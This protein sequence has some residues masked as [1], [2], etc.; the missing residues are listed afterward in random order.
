MSLSDQVALYAIRTT[1]PTHLQTAWEEYGETGSLKR[2]DA[3]RFGLFMDWLITGRR[4]NGQ[5]ILQKFEAEHGANLDPEERAELEKHKATHNGIY[6]VI[7]LRP[8]T[9]V[10]VKDIFTDEETEVADVSASRSAAIWD[11]LLMR[12]RRLGG[13]AQA[14]GEAIVFSPLNRDELKFELE[15]AYRTRKVYDSK[16]DWVSFLDSAT[17]LLRVLEA[18]FRTRRKTIVDS[19]H[20][21]E[22]S[23]DQELAAV[24]AQSG[25]RWLDERI[26]ALGG[27]TPR[28]AAADPEARG[29][30]MDLLKEYERNQACIPDGDDFAGY[31]NVAPIVWMRQTLGLPIPKALAARDKK[32][33]AAGRR[34]KRSA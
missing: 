19:E 30:L 32:I 18:E 25:E 12:L 20:V 27:R 17:P 7:A 5:T 23:S 4:E 29:F 28:E 21:V 1:G 16:L 11:V 6:E 15:A 24:I 14:W 31:M 33:A 22:V 2:P 34:K 3:E 13:P 26:P 8:G 10:T 9:G